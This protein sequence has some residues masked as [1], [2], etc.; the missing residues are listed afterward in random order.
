MGLSTCC[1]NRDPA[2][3]MT[4]KKLINGNGPVDLNNKM[5]LDSVLDE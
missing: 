5:D 3:K 4:T 2:E 1:T